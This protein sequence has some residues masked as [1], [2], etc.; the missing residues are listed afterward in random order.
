MSTDSDESEFLIQYF[1]NLILAPESQKPQPINNEYSS[2]ILYVFVHTNQRFDYKSWGQEYFGKAV[3]I[4]M[5]RRTQKYTILK[6]L[7]DQV[8]FQNFRHQEMNCCIK[9]TFHISATLSVQVPFDYINEYTVQ[10]DKTIYLLGKQ[11][12][13]K[14][15]DKIEFKSYKV[16]LLIN[17]TEQIMKVICSI[18]NSRRQ[19]KIL[20]GISYDKDLNGYVV[21][22]CF[23]QEKK[24]YQVMNSIM[25]KCKEFG[26]DQWVNIRLH[27]CGVLL[28]DQCYVVNNLKIFEIIINEGTNQLITIT[29]G[30]YYIRENGQSVP[31]KMKQLFNY[32]KDKMITEE[33]FEQCLNFYDE[34]MKKNKLI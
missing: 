14:E 19:G 34:L 8:L 30:K 33:E 18:L 28:Q 10:G 12:K 16:D 3:K 2:Q 20:I 31:I 29:P 7:S 22:G 23:C 32:W 17:N 15:D 9:P 1:S 11:C 5:F 6:L 4:S 13:L 25:N 26:C 21:S 27:E 24:A